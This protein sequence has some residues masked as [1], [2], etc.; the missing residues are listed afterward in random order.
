MQTLPCACS[1]SSWRVSA[2]SSC[3]YYK[4][5]QSSIFE[6]KVVIGVVRT[7]FFRRLKYARLVDA[8]EMEPLLGPSEGRPHLSA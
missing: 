5:N 2:K 1:S 6:S 4:T 8:C 7:V 3:S